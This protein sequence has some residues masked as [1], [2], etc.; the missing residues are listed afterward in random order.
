MDTLLIVL[1]SIEVVVDLFVLYWILKFVSNGFTIKAS[2]LKIR[3]KIIGWNLI[4]LK[5]LKEIGIMAAFFLGLGAL[6]LV[7]KYSIPFFVVLTIY[8][9]YRSF[10]P[11]KQE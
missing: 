1:L 5:D 10:K 3:D 2:L 6:F 8:V 4:S 7:P 11:M 9:I